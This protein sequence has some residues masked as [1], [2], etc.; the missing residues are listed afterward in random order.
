M[1][2][3]TTSSPPSH[4]VSELGH[5]G[6]PHPLAL[7]VF[8]ESELNWRTNPLLLSRSWEAIL[9]SEVSLLPEISPD[10][11]EFPHFLLPIF[12]PNPSTMYR[13]LGRRW[14]KP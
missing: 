10:P 11:N 13:G 9:D 2:R 3:A 7:D 6:F 4:G 1:E 14:E 8:S 12:T 5:E